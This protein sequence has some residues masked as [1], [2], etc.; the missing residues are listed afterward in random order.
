VTKILKKNTLFYSQRSSRWST[1]N[2]IRNIR[3]DQK[4]KRENLWKGGKKKFCSLWHI[5]STIQT[6]S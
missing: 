3:I 2:F 1:E 6:S 5:F 4:A